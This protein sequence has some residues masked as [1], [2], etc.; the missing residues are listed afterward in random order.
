M[1]TFLVGEELK[2][3]LAILPQYDVCIRKASKAERL[4]ALNQ[5]FDIYCSS[6]KQPLLTRKI[7]YAILKQKWE[8][9][10][11]KVGILRD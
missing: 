3:A 6:V 9:P 2:E 11:V 5:I 7:A 8:V 10:Y 4:L 1:D